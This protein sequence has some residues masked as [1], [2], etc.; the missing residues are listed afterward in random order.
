MKAITMINE[1]LNET[2]TSMK[3]F[4][5]KKE[6]KIELQNYYINDTLQCSIKISDSTVLAVLLEIVMPLELFQL[7]HNE[8]RDKINEIIE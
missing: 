8:I 2:G 7:C 3:I 6:L 1:V 5:S 4:D